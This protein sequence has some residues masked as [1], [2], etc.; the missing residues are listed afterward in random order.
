MT[1]PRLELRSRSTSISAFL[2]HADRS[3]IF[4]TRA[5]LVLIST[6]AVVVSAESGA[7][8]QAADRKVTTEATVSSEKLTAD[9]SPC[10]GLVDSS[11]RAA[12]GGDGAEAE[13]GLVAATRLCPNDPLGWLELA[14]LRGRDSRWKDAERLAEHATQLA[15]LDQRAWELLATSRYLA[16]DLRGALWAWNRVGKPLMDTIEVHG[17]RNTRPSV[18][19]DLV[20]I[21]PQQL[22]TPGAFLRASHRLDQLPVSFNTRVRYEPLDDGRARMDVYL[23]ERDILPHGLV[24]LGVIGVSALVFQELPF[25]VAGPTGSGEDWIAAW[26]WSENWRRVKFGLDAP[27]PGWLPGLVSV[28]AFWERHVFAPAPDIRSR[29]ERRHVGL[30]LSNWATS[31]LAW[32]AGGAFDRFGERSYGAVN[33]SVEARLAKDHMAVDLAGAVWKPAAGDQGFSTGRFA[34]TTRSTTKPQVPVLTTAVGAMLAT[35]DAPFA[36]WP[37]AGSNSVSDAPLRAH[38][39][40]H[41]SVV[42]GPAFGRRLVFGSIEYEH[43]LGHS[44]AGPVSVAGFVDAAQAGQRAGTLTTLLHVDAGIGVRLH[45][46]AIAGVMRL[47]VARGIRDG[48]MRVSV[49][50]T[51]KWPKRWGS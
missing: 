34:W 31:W 11:L 40:L 7:H 47:D 37:G 38:R 27:A 19:A 25:E 8:A 3:V 16:G 46:R 20:G 41:E 44:P 39:L 10:Q 36:L 5:A 30:G 29:E 1:L 26:R 18:V 33:G 9:G 13:R 21:Q 24:P 43:P 35:R 12:K 6:T 42:T 4:G 22:I 45:A 51:E 48:R 23:D 2:L 49:G 50:L 17:A 14:S 32:Q 15:P 28:D